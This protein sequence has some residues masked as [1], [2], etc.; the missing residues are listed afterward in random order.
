MTCNHGR[1]EVAFLDSPLDRRVAVT[2]ALSRINLRLR[3]GSFVLDFSDGELWYRNSI[4][5]ENGLLSERRVGVMVDHTLFLDDPDPF[6]V[7]ANQSRVVSS[8]FN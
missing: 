3:L 8:S 6:L 2:E 1:H 5:V 7:P 4:D